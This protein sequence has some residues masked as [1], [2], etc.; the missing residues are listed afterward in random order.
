MDRG[1]GFG[2]KGAGSGATSSAAGTG[3]G[4]TSGAAGTGGGTRAV[5]Q[6]RGN[7]TR[8]GRPW[9]FI[10]PWWRNMQEEDPE[11]QEM[12]EGLE[13]FWT[14]CEE[15]L[16]DL[17]DSLELGLQT[18]DADM[19]NAIRG[20]MLARFDQWDEE[21]MGFWNWCVR[22]RNRRASGTG[23]LTVQRWQGMTCIVDP[24]TGRWVEEPY[25][26]DDAGV[27]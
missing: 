12:V 14:T 6:A 24:L 1:K 21:E 16:Y 3:S 20:L 22:R 18:G 26:D 27:V 7:L 25:P 19:V 11:F 4:T 5:P 15:R 23:R 2:K 8:A 9:V 13:D 10:R 17:S